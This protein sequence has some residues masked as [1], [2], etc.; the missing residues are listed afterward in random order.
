MEYTTQNLSKLANISARTLRY[1]DEIGL[2]KPVRQ[3]SNGYR[4]YGQQE[5]DK[6][7][8][9]MFYKTMG[10]E[11]ETIKQL[12][13]NPDFDAIKAME[14]HLEKLKA[15]QDKLLSLIEYVDTTISY[16]KGETKMSDKE[17]FEIYKDEIIKSNEEKYGAE[18]REKYGD[19]SVDF[20]NMKIKGATKEQLDHIQT[21]TQQINETLKLA[22][23][24]GDTKGEKAQEMCK[25]H[26]EW[27]KFFWKEYTPQAHWGLCQMYLYDERFYAYYEKIA[28]KAADFLV[29]AMKYYLNM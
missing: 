19:E 2:L 26:Q 13:E 11:L 20:A 6:L 8:Q 4:I 5:V 14:N 27:I 15:E 3:S 18:A 9:I 23:E 21:L 29:E 16:L 10:L 7:Q 12:L 22:V 17:K 28:P 24:N 1:Y 25:L